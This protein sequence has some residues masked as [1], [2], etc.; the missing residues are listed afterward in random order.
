MHLFT[1]GRLITWKV[2][3]QLIDFDHDHRCQTESNCHRDRDRTQNGD[4]AGHLPSLQKAHKGCKNEA[5]EDGESDGDEYLAREIEDAD[6]N[7]ANQKIRRGKTC[8]NNH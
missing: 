2:V 1:K 7:S 3:R 6:Y 8:G 4:R 5:Q